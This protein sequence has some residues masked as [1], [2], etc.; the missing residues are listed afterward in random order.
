MRRIP[1]RP[2]TEWQLEVEALGLTWHTH[3]DGTP[4][5]NESACY[6][7]SAAQI[8]ELEAATN[9]LHQ[10]CVQAVA[11]VID[12][13]R[14]AELGIPPAAVPLIQRSWREKAP[15]LY[16]RFD[17]AYDGTHPPKML[18]YNA[19]TPTSLLEA[20]VIQW[21]W[22]ESER[23]GAD[24]FNSLW[25]A[26]VARWTTLKAA[27]FLGDGPLCMAYSGGE[28]DEDH[29]TV[30]CMM[31]ETAKEAGIPSQALP[32]KE[33]GWNTVRG[34][35]GPGDQP[36]RTVFK[37]FPWEWMWSDPFGVHLTEA[38]EATRWIEPP[39]KLVL[40]SKGILALLWELFPDHPN[41]LPTYVHR[42][43]SLRDYVRKPFFSR[44]GA[45]VAIVQGGQTLQESPGTYASDQCV[46]QAYSPL[47]DFDGHHPVLG[48][49][50]IGNEAHGLGI[51]ES[52]GLITDNL[53]Q[54]VPHYFE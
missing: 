20:A 12:H 37:L 45:N 48:S 52:S 47:P 36:L 27:R 15:S 39:W 16:G 2:R 41:L 43:D 42:P 31:Q 34:F 3:A 24:Q 9:D 25:E 5:W 10:L 28:F 30:T 6:V 11:H 23:P 38:Y 22:L 4:Y 50:I 17:L 8:D 13:N 46:Y 53:S 26:V 18:E 19:D 35:V 7:F 14:F 44:E 1:C 33:I 29:M 49:W 21:Y 32:I 40:S 51:R 54:F